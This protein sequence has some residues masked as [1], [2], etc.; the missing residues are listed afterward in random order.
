MAT[1]KEQIAALQKGWSAEI[2]NQEQPGIQTGIKTGSLSFDNKN[3]M[4][5]QYPNGG[6]TVMRRSPNQ[7]GLGANTYR[8]EILDPETG[9]V[10][11][12][13][14]S[15]SR[16]ADIGGKVLLA[17]M[18]V[19]T[20]NPQL[21]ASLGGAEAAAAAGADVVGADLAAS[22]V[23]GVEGVAS[24]AG[25]T[26]YNS[27]IASGLS[28]AD[29]AAFA[30]KAVSSTAALLEAGFSEAEALRTSLDNLGVQ[31]SF[32]VGDTG[33]LQDAA[34]VVSGLP[35]SALV[36]GGLLAA[37][38]VNS[39][40]QTRQTTDAA[41]NVTYNLPPQMQFQ[42]REYTPATGNLYRYGFGPEQAMFRGTGPTSTIGR[43][44]VVINAPAA[45][46]QVAAPAAGSPLATQSLAQQG[47]APSG[48]LAA[49]VNGQQVPIVQPVDQA[50]VGLL[51]QGV[52]VTQ[53]QALTRDLAATIFQ[54]FFDR[55]PTEREIAT[56]AQYGDRFKTPE[57]FSTF[58]MNSPQYQAYRDSLLAAR[59]QPVAPAGGGTTQTVVQQTG[60]GSPT[61]VNAPMDM[62][63]LGNE[64]VVSG[65][66][67]PAFSGGLFT[68]M[69]TTNYITNDQ[70]IDVFKS[71]TGYA[72]TQEQVA[73]F[74]G[75]NTFT[76]PDAFRAF[77]TGTPDYQ[78]MAAQGM[79]PSM[80]GL[81]QTR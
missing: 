58:L 4:V 57:E 24:Q 5:F 7:A 77:L 64:S 51:N 78:F 74:S 13:V 71:L 30:D 28:M 9:K 6:V 67:A 68:A 23:A 61:I 80:N 76:S 59:N 35:T 53:P 27:A 60:G 3:W 65:A 38:A 70:A 62:G 29:A 19:L 32:R 8:A 31:S 34:N 17:T 52:Q 63:L 56:F 69:P 41:G 12:T 39:A 11:E 73:A 79:L 18:A 16:I 44:N 20:T 46:G 42:G 49:N 21:A 15:P 25:L 33:L 40:L 54:G 47:M 36:T 50:T 72:P 10:E 75:A 48:L 26:A 81:L 1:L 45:Q 37:N 2:A 66:G 43:S 55:A 14:V 22:A